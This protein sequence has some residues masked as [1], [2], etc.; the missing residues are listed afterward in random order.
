M[1]TVKEKLLKTQVVKDYQKKNYNNL[2]KI[3]SNHVGQSS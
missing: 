3:C 1:L 2:V